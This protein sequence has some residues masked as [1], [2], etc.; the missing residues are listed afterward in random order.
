MKG[1]VE[2]GKIVRI[3]NKAYIAQDGAFYYAGD[4]ITGKNNKPLSDILDGI[5]HV[6]D[7]EGKRLIIS[8]TTSTLYSNFFSRLSDYVDDFNIK[9]SET[10]DEHENTY[11]VLTINAYIN[12]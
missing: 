1:K 3:E 11:V 5:F 12:K 2:D 6:E 10:Y 4:I 7:R 9:A 8:E